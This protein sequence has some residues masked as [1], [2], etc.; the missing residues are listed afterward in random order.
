MKEPNE[1]SLV[2]E[3]SLCIAVQVKPYDML[4][5]FPVDVKQTLVQSANHQQTY[6]N[7]RSE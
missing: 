2:V 1:I 6:I 4:A 3:S 5:N 7:I